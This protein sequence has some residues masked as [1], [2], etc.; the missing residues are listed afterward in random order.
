[1]PYSAAL[2]SGKNGPALRRKE[3]AGTSQPTIGC[4]MEETRKMAQPTT[5]HNRDENENK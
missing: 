2:A 4:W 3:N 5:N 1:M